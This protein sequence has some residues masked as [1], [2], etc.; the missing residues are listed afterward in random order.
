MSPLT[1][2]IGPEAIEARVRGLAREIDAHYR[3]EPLVCVCVLKGAFM[4]FADLVRHL[5]CGPELDFI[6]L[7]SYGGGTSSTG[8]VRFMHDVETSLEGKHVLVVDDIVDSGRS[9][10]YLLNIL[11]RRGTLSVKLC[12]LLDKFE[13][14]EVE[15]KVDF[16]GFP[17]KE[18]FVVGYGMDY[19]EHYR[20]LP[21]VFEV[22]P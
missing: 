12:A 3:G 5:Q 19:G 21:G 10:E 4:F 17:L 2:V 11:S 16:P 18:G 9:M 1:P 7:A 6:R 22:K 15:L 8:K 20:E 13:R 14:R